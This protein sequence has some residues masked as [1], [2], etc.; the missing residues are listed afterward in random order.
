MNRLYKILFAASLALS[1][2]LPFSAVAE[3]AVPD[4]SVPP[5][6][7]MH[8]LMREMRQGQDAEK[9]KTQIK[10]DVEPDAVSNG[11]CKNNNRMSEERC[12]QGASGKAPC[13]EA[14]KTGCKPG[15]CMQDMDKPCMQQCAH[16]GCGMREGDDDA[17]LN[18]LEKRMDMMQLMLEMMLRSSGGNR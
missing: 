2:N 7:T 3:D 16:K 13:K 6:H 10:A 17:R 11:P 1:L 18:D 9:C 4:A 5:M 14:C 8:D 15:N 12:R